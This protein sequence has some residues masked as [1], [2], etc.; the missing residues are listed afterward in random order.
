MYLNV[1]VVHDEVLGQEVFQCATLDD[2]HFR[3]A[4]EAID[5]RVYAALELAPVL[6]EGLH[7]RL[8]HRKVL[9]ELLQVVVVVDLFKLVLG[10]NLLQLPGDFFRELRCLFRKLLLHF[11]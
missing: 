1:A 8:C 2:F 7:L 9:V 4:L 3:V 5:H 11:E 6:F 10:G